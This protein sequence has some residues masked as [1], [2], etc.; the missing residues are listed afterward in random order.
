[1]AEKLVGEIH[2]TGP[3]LMC[4]SFKVGATPHKAA[5]HSAT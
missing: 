3:V 5:I 4:F 1:L 2:A